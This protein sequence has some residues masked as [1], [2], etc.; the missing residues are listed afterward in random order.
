M[1]WVWRAHNEVNERL[2]RNE[3]KYGRSSTATCPRLTVNDSGFK[4]VSAAAAA[5]AAVIHWRNGLLNPL[6][7]S[8]AC[9]HLKSGHT[10]LS[11]T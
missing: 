11:P 1:F 10:A 3:A 9:L 5:A 6:A 2:P 7:H 8:A 4:A